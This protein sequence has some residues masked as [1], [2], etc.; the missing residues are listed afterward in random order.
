MQHFY[1]ADIDAIAI[2]DWMWSCADNCAAADS[3]C[4]LVAGARCPYRVCMRAEGRDPG[5]YAYALRAGDPMHAGGRAGGRAGG[6]GGGGGVGGGGWVG[7]A[8]QR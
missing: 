4:Y 7:G 2:G 8:G 6:G 1:A 5:V 3:E